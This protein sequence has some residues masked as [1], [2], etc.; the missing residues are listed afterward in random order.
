M[1]WLSWKLSREKLHP[2]IIFSM[3]LTAIDR[4][5]SFKAKN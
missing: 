1:N 2:F 3:L 4:F 5:V